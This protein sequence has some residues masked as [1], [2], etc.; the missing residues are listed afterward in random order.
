MSYTWY[1]LEVSIHRVR[2]ESSLRLRTFPELRWSSR[3]HYK[4]PRE[5]GLLESGR[6]PRRDLPWNPSLPP[7]SGV[8][9]RWRGNNRHLGEAIAHLS[10][11]R[12]RGEG[13]SLRALSR[14]QWIMNGTAA[15]LH[16]RDCF[17]KMASRLF[18]VRVDDLDFYCIRTHVTTPCLHIRSDLYACESMTLNVACITYECI[19]THVTALFL[20]SVRPWNAYSVH[21]SRWPRMCY[22][23][24]MYLHLA[25][26]TAM[27]CLRVS[28]WPWM[29]LA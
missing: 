9:A 15:F 12:L 28:R 23:C 7:W 25:Y 3:V 29:W 5:L 10:K 8:V 26:I 18:W 27:I 14:P 21:S 13:H 16:L 11:G 17:P 2:A 24:S 4:T 6:S 19:R 1:S 20:H 22:T